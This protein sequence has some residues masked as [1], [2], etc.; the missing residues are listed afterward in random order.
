MSL[1]GTARQAEIKPAIPSS[2]PLRQ[3]KCT[4]LGNSQIPNIVSSN[5]TKQESSKIKLKA[6]HQK[7]GF[8]GDDL[9]L[10]D[11]LEAGLSQNKPKRLDKTTTFPDDDTEW[12]SIDSSSSPPRHIPDLG[13][14]KYEECE[15]PEECYEPVRLLN[16]NWACNHR[17]K[18]KTR[19][20]TRH[21]PND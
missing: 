2:L 13:R 19:Q 10:D 18:D 7:D 15:A 5:P 14:D 6:S 17:C 12:I 9:Q 16:G 20:A 1:A 11:F 21:D 4:A 3:N 8:E